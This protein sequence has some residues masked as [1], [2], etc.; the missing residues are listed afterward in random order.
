MLELRGTTQL[1]FLRTGTW[2]WGQCHDLYFRQFLAKKLAFLFKRQYYDPILHQL[3]VIIPQKT[4][5]FDKFFRRFFKI[6]TSVL[7]L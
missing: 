6:T 3:A 1:Y 4:P 2:A 7:G 5:F